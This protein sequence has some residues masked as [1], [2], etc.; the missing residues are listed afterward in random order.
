MTLCAKR[1]LFLLAALLLADGSAFLLDPPG[2]IRLWSSPRAPRW[3]RRAMS[4]FE[5]HV[6]FCRALSVAEI[7]LGLALLARSRPPGRQRQS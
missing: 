5:G 3:Y 6:A 7:A 1:A 2:Q 4:F